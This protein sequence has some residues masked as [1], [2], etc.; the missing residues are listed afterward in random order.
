MHPRTLEVIRATVTEMRGRRRFAELADPRALINAV[1]SEYEP[2]D[3]AEERAR[4]EKTARLAE[5]YASPLSVLIGPA[6]TG[7]TTP[8]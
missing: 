3:E 5:L 4:A 2:E 7:K 1:L 8:W 6:G